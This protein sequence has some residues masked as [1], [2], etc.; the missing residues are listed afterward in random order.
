MFQ[1]TSDGVSR[2]DMKLSGKLDADAMRVA[3]DQLLEASNGIED[4]VMLYDIVDFHLP[5]MGAVMVEFSRMPQL[6]GLIRRFRKAAVLAEERWIR[7]A[8]EWESAFVPHMHI[9]AFTH[10]QRPEAEAWLAGPDET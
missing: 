3:L 2:L 4:G 10:D 9:R 1:V 8:S 5:S 6:F 7:E